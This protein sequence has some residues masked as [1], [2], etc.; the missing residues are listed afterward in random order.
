MGHDL[1]RLPGSHSNHE[2]DWANLP[3][4]VRSLC[5][6]E[7]HPYPGFPQQVDRRHEMLIRSLE[8]WFYEQ[9]KAQGLSAEV[10]GMC[11]VHER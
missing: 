6:R 10:A 7:I 8:P 3:R 1:D 9:A 4:V 11:R 5:N 2:V